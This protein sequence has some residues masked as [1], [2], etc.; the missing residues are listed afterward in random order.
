MLL[1]LL[2]LDSGGQYSPGFTLKVL[3]E[4]FSSSSEKDFLALAVLCLR[5]SAFV[6]QGSKGVKDMLKV[7]LI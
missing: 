6:Q 2:R 1:S 5:S 7:W 3:V 4:V